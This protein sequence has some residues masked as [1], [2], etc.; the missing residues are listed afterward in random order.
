M[1]KEQKKKLFILG[2]TI[3]SAYLGHEFM[4]EFFGDSIP[5]TNWPV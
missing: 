3:L 4:E 1:D 5:E 2:E